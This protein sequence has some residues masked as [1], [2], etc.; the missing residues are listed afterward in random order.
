MNPSRPTNLIKW[1]AVLGACGAVAATSAQAGGPPADP[2]W[3][4][5]PHCTVPKIEGT[6]L[7]SAKTKLHG[8][9]CGSLAPMRL[10]SKAARNTVLTVIPQAGTQLAPGTKVLLIV[11]K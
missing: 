9:L 4:G 1:T 3:A 8:S 2:G 7:T 6:L 11:A 5:I 10:A